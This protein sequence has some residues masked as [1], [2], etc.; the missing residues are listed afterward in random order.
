MNNDQ[1]NENAVNLPAVI[2]PFLGGLAAFITA[3]LMINGRYLE[4]GY[5]VNSKEYG[6]AG[7]QVWGLNIVFAL[8]TTCLMLITIACMAIHKIR[9][10]AVKLWQAMIGFVA[11]IIAL[12]AFLPPPFEFQIRNYQDA[13]NMTYIFL[14]PDCSDGV[15]GNENQFM[16]TMQ[17][18]KLNVYYGK[19]DNLQDDQLF[20][21]IS[22][23][24]WWW[25]K[26]TVDQQFYPGLESDE[27]KLLLLQQNCKPITQEEADKRGLSTV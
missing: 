20:I 25:G 24:V 22:S 4:I 14:S 12:I 8:I 17:E 5:V 18:E 11:L 16:G 9:G 23:D 27:N 15:V 19:T 21:C 2:F 6:I 7:S 10:R 1:L 26:L 13:A 3:I